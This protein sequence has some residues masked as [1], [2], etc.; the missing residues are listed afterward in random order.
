MPGV[1]G[2]LA[3][4]VLMVRWLKRQGAHPGICD[5]T[6]LSAYG[7]TLRLNRDG[8]G[9][10]FD[11]VYAAFQEEQEKPQPF[12]NR[13][14]DIVPP[15]REEVRTDIDPRSGPRGAFLTDDD[16]SGD[17]GLWIKLWRD[18]I[19]NIF[20]GVPKT[21]KPFEDRAAGKPSKDAAAVWADLIQPADYP[22][23]LPSTYFI[24]A[25]AVNAENIPFTDRARFQFL[26]HFWPYVA[27]VY[28]PAVCSNEGKRTFVGFALAIPDVA[29]L[30]WFCEELPAVLRKRGVERSGYRPKDSI[31]DVAVESALDMLRRLRE[32]LAVRTGT[33]ARVI[34]YSGLMS[35]IWTNKET[36]SRRLASR[37]LTLSCA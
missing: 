8:L 10:L 12:R 2:S 20:R 33:Q 34:G 11:E 25:Q 31:V 28:V 17:H 19:W 16:P 27:Q 1:C 21:R 15:L 23:A 14:K 3:G 4:L 5:I 26:L 7:A 32:R 6:R 29:N 37:G 30:E 35:S 22:V 36:T 24:G 13:Q 18:V 9:A